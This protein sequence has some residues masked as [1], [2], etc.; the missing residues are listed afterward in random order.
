MMSKENTPRAA[1]PQVTTPTNAQAPAQAP[2]SFAINAQYVKDLSFEGPAHPSHVTPAVAPKIDVNVTAQ[3]ALLENNVFEVVIQV[4]AEATIDGKKAFIIELAYAGIVALPPGL[5]ENT[6]RFLLLVEVPRY[7]FPF[8]R[9]IIAS[10]TSDGG[11]PPL[12]LQPIDF[13]ALY[14]QQLQQAAQAG[15]TGRA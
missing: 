13:S 3:T 9:N 15:Q 8:A 14:L 2:V 10:C 4:R 5:D 12:M 6:V 11:F 1:P 7:L